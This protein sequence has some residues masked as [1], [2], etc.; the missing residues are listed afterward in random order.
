MAR[1]KPAISASA[2]ADRYVNGVARRVAEKWP[3]LAERLATAYTSDLDDA[4]GLTEATLAAAGVGMR[5]VRGGIAPEVE[6]R[7]RTAVASA[8]ASRFAQVA[9]AEIGESYEELWMS[10]GDPRAIGM[11]FVLRVVGHDPGD[12]GG[13]RPL[14]HFTVEKI[15]GGAIVEAAVGAWTEILSGNTIQP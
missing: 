5:E 9:A 10:T 7:L 13:G 11:G 4:V 12:T 2:A 1:P 14:I 15:V 3:E 6:G 8:L